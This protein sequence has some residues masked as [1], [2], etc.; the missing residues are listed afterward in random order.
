MSKKSIITT[1]ITLTALC[2][3]CVKKVNCEGIVYSKIGHKKVAGAGVTLSV[4]TS[5]KDA[6]LSSYSTT[7]DE[8]GKYRFSEFLSK[9]R[10]FGFGCDA[11]DDGWFHSTNV[12]REGIRQYDIHLK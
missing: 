10:T 3:S 5:G 7:T 8:N 4:Y 1:I 6:S 2:L 12:S 11:G 9:N